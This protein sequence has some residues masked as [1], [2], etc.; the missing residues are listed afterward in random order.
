M[1][2][3]LDTWLEEVGDTREMPEDEM[4]ARFQP[5]GEPEVTPAPALAIEGRRVSL[6]SEVAGA[7]LA[8]C[9]EQGRWRLYTKPFEAPHGSSVRAKAVRYGWEESDEATLRLS[10]E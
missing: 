7:S 6:R 8:Y 2:S 5:R 4:V 9:I 3:A 1:R 10:I